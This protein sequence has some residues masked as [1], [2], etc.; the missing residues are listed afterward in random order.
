MLSIGPSTRVYLKSGPT[1]LRL[2]YEGSIKWSVASW[3]RILCRVTSLRSAIIAPPGSSCWCGMV[4]AYGCVRKTR[5]GDLH[6]PL[7]GRPIR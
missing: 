4:P 2:G 1:D 3:A 7:E 5:A 6:L